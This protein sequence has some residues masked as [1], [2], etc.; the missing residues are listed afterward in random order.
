MIK[1]L[2]GAGADKSLVDAVKNFKCGSCYN[3]SAP[4]NTP[5]VKPP[6]LYMFNR[7]VILCTF[8]T[9]DA[10]KNRLVWLNV[11]CDGTSYHVAFVVHKGEGIHNSKKCST[12]FRSIGNLILDSRKS[13]HAAE[14]LTQRGISCTVL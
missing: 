12:H 13:S 2:R 3:I 4:S 14:A 8:E 9:K 10:E 5:P 7:E 11:I 1:I 6:S